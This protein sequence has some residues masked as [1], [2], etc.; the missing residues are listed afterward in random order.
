MIFGIASS[1]KNIVYVDSKDE[2]YGDE[3]SNDNNRPDEE[4]STW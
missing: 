1:N 2:Q 3:G 4:A